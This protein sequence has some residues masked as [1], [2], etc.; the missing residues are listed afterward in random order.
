[1]TVSRIFSAVVGCAAAGLFLGILTG[2]AA[3][4]AD[5]ERAAPERVVSM[6]LCA[7]ELLLRLADPDQIVSVTYLGQNPDQSTVAD[8]A[9][10]YPANHGL[11]E[12]ILRLSPDLVVAGR[13]TTRTTVDFLRRV[14]EPVLELEVPTTLPEVEAQIRMLG[15]RLGQ[16]ERAE[17]MVA[18][19]A[20]AF[21]GPATPDDDAPTA[22]VFAPNGFTVGAGSLVDTVI[23]AAGLRNL[24]AEQD[25]GR[26]RRL[27][28]EQL[29][30]LKPDV[31]ILNAEETSPALAYEVLHHP[32]LDRLPKAPLVVSLSPRLWTCAGPAL[33]DALALLRQAAETIETHR[34]AG[35]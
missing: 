21:V 8:K 17:A 5:D 23:E 30:R 12:E 1:M 27:S 16:S 26:Y 3:S 32:I 14:G 34:R 6:N 9:A 15:D 2:P 20:G 28:L 31:L 4:M 19:I 10:R 11:A 24:G 22:V 13:Y 35:Q 7:D 18:E 25:L 33:V 29:A